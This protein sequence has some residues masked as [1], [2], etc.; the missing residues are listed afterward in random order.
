V[1]RASFRRDVPRSILST[2][3]RSL[4]V[5]GLFETH[6]TVSN[7]DRSVAFY[8][9]FIGLPVAFEL[10]ERGASFLWIGRPGEAML[11]LWSPGSAPI[12]LSLHVAFRTSLD[13]VLRACDRLR[14]LGLTPL[15]FGATETDEPS[16]IGWM[17]A[18]AVYL[19]DPDGHLLEY[20][21]ML[22]EAARA[23]LGIVP[24]SRWTTSREAP[25][26]APAIDWFVGP[27]RDL[28]ELFELADDSAVQLDSYLER[29]R[30]LVARHTRG[31][32]VGHVQLIPAGTGVVEIKSLAVRPAVQGREVGTRLVEHALAICRAELVET[33]TVATAM[34]DAGNLRFYQRC[35][36]RVTSIE[37]DAFTPLTGY[38]AGLVA[39]GIPVRDAI[40]FTLELGGRP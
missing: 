31:E 1:V 20:L 28:R 8:R 7:L 11:G 32:V 22:P 9:D 5:D 18:A 24:W 13:D 14:S 37:P 40:R 4:P 27:R 26:Q 35:G 23:D 16:V 15:S 17:P 21:A 36:F 3:K 25:D 10:P 12:G 6:L 30:V 38:P 29:G 39:D 34:A 33:V 2:R 19:R